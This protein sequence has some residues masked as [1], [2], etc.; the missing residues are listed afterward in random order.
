MEIK[1]DQCLLN[2]MVNC[3]ERRCQDCGWNPEVKAQRIAAWLRNRRQQRF[4][5]ACGEGRKQHVPVL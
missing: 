4:A 1:P 5:E 2:P 3:C